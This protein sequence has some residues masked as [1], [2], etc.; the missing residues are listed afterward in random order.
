MGGRLSAPHHPVMLPASP[1][2]YHRRYGGEAVPQGHQ[3]GVYS[4]YLTA[5]G[6]TRLRHGGIRLWAGTARHCPAFGNACKCQRLFKTANRLMQAHQ[7]RL[8]L[9]FP[10]VQG[11]PRIPGRKIF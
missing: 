3:K 8:D 4:P 9:P 6:R 11:M 5:P 10:A 7:D 1:R 2:P